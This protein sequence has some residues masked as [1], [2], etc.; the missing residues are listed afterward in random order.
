MVTLTLA[1]PEPHLSGFFISST[2]ASVTSQGRVGLSSGFEP[3][4]NICMFPCNKI[5]LTYSITS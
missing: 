5:Y 3:T 4:Y 2:L 1:V